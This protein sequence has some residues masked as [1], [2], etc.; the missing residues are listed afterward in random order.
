MQ[1]FS[2]GVTNDIGRFSPVDA[3]EAVSLRGSPYSNNPIFAVF[4]LLDL[5]FIF[6]V[7][8]S[9]FAILFTYDAINGEREAGTLRLT[10]ANAVPRV[11]YLA[12]HPSLAYSLPR[13]NIT[14]PL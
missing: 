1:I 10:F 2:S 7:V 4:R 3:T 13:N 8:I 9:L 6:L 14:C 11:K 5:N 12:T